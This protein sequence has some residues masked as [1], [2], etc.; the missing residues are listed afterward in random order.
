MNTFDDY[1]GLLARILDTE[2]PRYTYLSYHRKACICVID[3]A[4]RG[5]QSRLAASLL[6]KAIDQA[7]DLSLPAYF[8]EL[9]WR[10]NLSVRITGRKSLK[11]RLLKKMM[12]LELLRPA[13]LAWVTELTND[14]STDLT[15]DEVNELVRR[16]KGH[17]YTALRE[18]AGA[19][20]EGQAL[21]NVLSGLSRRESNYI[22][23]QREE[24]RL[25]TP[26]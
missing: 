14:S 13:H 2:Q 19:H 3:A 6:E 20:L 26:G 22:D 24:N 5:L 15:V 8:D 4:P 9:E 11:K 18:F 12:S 10:H 23:W 1:H 25:N 17:E 7:V 21:S 16:Y